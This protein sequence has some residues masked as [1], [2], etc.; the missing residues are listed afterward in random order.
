[1]VSMVLAVAEGSYDVHLWPVLSQET[2]L[3]SVAHVDTRDQ[4][5]FLDPCWLSPETR[6]KS[7]IHV[8][9]DCKGQGSFFCHGID[10]RRVTIEK[11]TEASVTILLL[12]YSPSPS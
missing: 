10:D 2:T 3:R 6:C 12:L 7:L 9:A 8:P 4:V 11:D 1:M 5:D